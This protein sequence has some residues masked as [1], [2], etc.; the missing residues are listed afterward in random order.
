M[1]KT[2]TLFVFAI[3]V[4]FGACPWAVAGNILIDPGHSPKF[5][6]AISC[7]GVAEYRYNNLLAAEIANYLS[8]LG[9]N[10]SLTKSENS[11]ISWSKRAALSKG[12][13]LLV[14]IHHDSVQPQFVNHTTGGGVCSY[15]AKGFS[16]FIS[17]SNRYF[18]ESLHYAKM[19]GNAMVHRGYRSTLH[20]AE[21]IP[22]EFKILLDPTLG[23]YV[24]N[25]LIVLKQAKAPAILF[26][27]AVIVHPDDEAI[28]ASEGYR[29]AIAES[30]AVMVSSKP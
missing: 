24:F 6:G 27:A 19:L 4:L 18:K 10:V 11:V 22:G 13:D 17:R 9:H 29:H 25:N 26:E 28:A 3:A 20:H 1:T 21:K 16:I 23:I 14:S 12:Q 8:L 15:K 7:S 2:K 5:P 30:V